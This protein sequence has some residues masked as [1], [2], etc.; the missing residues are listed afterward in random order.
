MF[1]KGAM[2]IFFEKRSNHTWYS[3]KMWKFSVNSTL[4]IKFILHILSPRSVLCNYI[5]V[6]PYAFTVTWV[7]PQTS[8][9][10]YFLKN[11]HF[12]FKNCL[13]V[14]KEIILPQK[15]TSL[16]HLLL[17]FMR[18]IKKYVSSVKEYPV[19]HRKQLSE[20]PHQP[21]QTTAWLTY[22]YITASS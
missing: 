20:N 6:I 17:C 18:W 21:W 13:Y 14:Y 1:F 15:T 4:E 11:Q 22:M 16:W 8:N 19:K 10:H 9:R 12:I 2:R 3:L 5:L 7:S